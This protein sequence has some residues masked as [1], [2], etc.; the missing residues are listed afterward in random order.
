MIGR[1]HTSRRRPSCGLILALAA[2]AV[3]LAAPALAASLI[4]SQQ[5]KDRTIR[6]A[7][8][9]R[10]ARTALAGPAGQT[11][12][13][14]APGAAGQ[15]GPQGP[16]GRKG[17]TGPVGASGATGPDGPVGAGFRS[18]AGVVSETGPTHFGA[19][20][21]IAT[22]VIPEVGWSQW[23]IRAKTDID[24]IQGDVDNFVTCDLLYKPTAGF[25]AVV[26]HATSLMGYHSNGGASSVTL[27]LQATVAG[28]TTG[29]NARVTCGASATPN[30]ALAI[31]AYHTKIEAIPVSSLTSTVV[32]G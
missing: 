1:L 4:T 28:A 7:D 24:S 19:S 29:A 16:A 12:G 17:D 27:P 26:D 8:F 3:A 22:L 18:I 5:I 25:G 11:G 2:L 21:L 10:S 23:L 20:T 32:G 30:P 14:G 9:S 15:R 6:L 31:S 13:D